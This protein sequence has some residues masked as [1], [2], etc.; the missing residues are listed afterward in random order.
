MP[1]KHLS[2][3]RK[4]EAVLLY[5]ILKGYKMDVGKIIEKSIYNYYCSNY[6]GLIPHPS[7][8]TRLCILGRVDFD[9]EKEEICSKTSPLI[10]T[11]ITKPPSNKG[12]EK[13]QEIEEGSKDIEQTEQAIVVSIMKTIEEKQRSATPNWNL[14]PDVREYHYEQD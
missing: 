13:V 5:A 14:P 1:S 8:I 9:R 11:A 2:I 12:K 4:E 10:L 6:R 3:V 7:T